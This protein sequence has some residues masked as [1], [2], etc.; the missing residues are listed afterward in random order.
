MLPMPAYLDSAQWR[1]AE[2]MPEL[3][4]AVLGQTTFD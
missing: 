2:D 3:Q 1:A 4:L